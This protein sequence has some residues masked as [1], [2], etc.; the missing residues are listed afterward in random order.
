MYMYILY[1]GV[2]SCNHIFSTSTH[3]STGVV[4]SGEDPQDASGCKSF[5]AK[6]PIITGLFCRK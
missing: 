2:H 5:S 6:E 1:T 3:T 4:K